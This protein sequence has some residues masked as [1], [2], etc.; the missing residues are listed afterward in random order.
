M[1][2]E[3]FLLPAYP[4][5]LQARETNASWSSLLV[6]QIRYMLRDKR[7][8]TFAMVSR[9][10]HQIHDELKQ[11]F[12]KHATFRITMPS[13]G[14]DE[15]FSASNGK[16]NSA[17]VPQIKNLII[18]FRTKVGSRVRR[19]NAVA[20]VEL[21]VTANNGKPTVTWRKRSSEQKTNGWEEPLTSAETLVMRAARKL[22]NEAGFGE[23]SLNELLLLAWDAQRGVH[24]EGIG[25][26]AAPTPDW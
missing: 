11:Y 19:A 5:R 10:A 18:R 24:P 20:P 17:L 7:L 14:T 3:M 22:L 13:F 16:M 4:F 6:I 2:Y 15:Y 1:I 25:A 8:R 9:T 26:I 23:E 12:E 21:K